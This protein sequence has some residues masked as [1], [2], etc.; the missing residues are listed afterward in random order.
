MGLKIAIDT[1]A[2]AE[3]QNIH[4]LIDINDINDPII[5]ASKSIDVLMPFDW[6]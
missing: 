2:M 3:S 4:A 1:L 6:P 5:T